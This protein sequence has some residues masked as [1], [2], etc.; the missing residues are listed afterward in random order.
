[1]EPRNI[2]ADVGVQSR[3]EWRALSARLCAGGV[4][5]VQSGAGPLQR[6]NGTV[7]DAGAAHSQQGGL[8]HCRQLRVFPFHHLPPPVRTHGPDL[9]AKKSRSIFFWPISWYRRV[10]RAS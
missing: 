4:L 10:I 6:P 9:S 1:M 2:Y 5:V 3:N 8:P 7:V